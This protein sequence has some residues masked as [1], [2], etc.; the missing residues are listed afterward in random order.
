MHALPGLK[1]FLDHVH[2]AGNLFEIRLLG[3]S[4]RTCSGLFDSS[5]TAIPALREAW[6]NWPEANF[7]YTLNPINPTSAYAHSTPRNRIIAH[8]KVTA[9]DADILARTLYL[10]DVDPVRE[11]GRAST[12]RQRSLARELTRQVRS[13]LADGGWPTPTLVSSGNGYHLLYKADRC[14]PQTPHLQAALVSLAGRFDTESVKIDRCVHNAARISRLPWTFNRKGLDTPETP[15]RLAKV[16]K[17]G[18]PHPVSEAALAALAPAPS[19][20]NL[21]DGERSA[22]KAAGPN[23]S[24]LDPNRSPFPPQCLLDEAGIHRLLDSYREWLPLTRVYR[25]GVG[26]RFQLASCPVKGGPH[27]HQTAGAGKTA[28]LWSPGSLGFKCFSDDCC[29]ETIGSVLRR[30]VRQTGRSFPTPIW[31]AA[32]PSA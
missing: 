7:Y 14:Q 25:E 23:R 31:G 30:I 20:G 12:M 16:L 2:P 32:H 24:A 9:R 11:S 8:P 6:K 13:F 26:V 28:I 27:L 3:Q 5:E 29:N 21:E 4:P 22:G 15:H 1:A 19:Q 10:I 17:L 18:S